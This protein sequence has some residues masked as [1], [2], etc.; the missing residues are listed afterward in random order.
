M[1]R[2]FF[3]RLLDIVLSIILI[4]FSLVILLICGIRIKLDDGGPVFYLAGRLGKGGKQFSMFKLRT[5]KVNAPDIRVEDGSTW[6]SEDDFRVTRTGRFLRKTS[7]DEV[8]QI[9][10]VLKGD[11]SLIGPRPDTVDS[12]DRY[13]SEQAGRLSVLPGITGYCQA[14]FRNSINAAE[15]LE[16]DIYYV[17]NLSF[18]FDLKIILKTAAVIFKHDNIYSSAVYKNPLTEDDNKPNRHD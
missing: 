18:L 5:M 10:N 13:T 15:K 9:F 4:P 1:Y 7:L 6:N 3:K 12:L 8:P 2:I 14:Y 11:M 16:K 17:D